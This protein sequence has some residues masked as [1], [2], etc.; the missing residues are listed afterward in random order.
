MR[1]PYNP[2]ATDKNVYSLVTIL[3]ILPCYS[4]F[5]L[6]VLSLHVNIY[7]SILFLTNA[8][9]LVHYMDAHTVFN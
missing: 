4:L 7:T 6:S 3:N 2:T 8:Y 5:S 1:F 9:L